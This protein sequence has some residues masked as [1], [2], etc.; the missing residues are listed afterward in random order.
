MKPINTNADQSRHCIP[1][2]PKWEIRIRGKRSLLCIEETGSTRGAATASKALLPVLEQMARDIHAE[3][4]RLEADRDELME[5]LEYHQ[6][7]TRPI[8]RTIDV[9]AKVKGGA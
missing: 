6:K 1:V 7:Q 3:M 4:S 9:I 8:Q 2:H 5:A